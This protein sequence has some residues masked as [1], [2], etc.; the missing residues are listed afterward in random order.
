[1]DLYKW[2]FKLSPF[3]PSELVADCFELARDIREID[4]RASP[5]DLTSLGFAPIAVETVEGRFE[6]EHHQRQFAV[7]GEPL[8]TQL[9][10]LCDWLL[11]ADAPAVAHSTSLHPSLKM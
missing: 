5:Y 1:M 6:Y 9:I 2:A 7:R 4:M 11:N 3:T 8:R 10:A